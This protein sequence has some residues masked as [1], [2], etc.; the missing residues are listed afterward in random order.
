MK[1]F[2]F[3]LI[4]IFS[5]I[6]HQVPA[7]VFAQEASTIVDPKTTMSDLAFISPK[8]YSFGF[9]T[10]GDM[11]EA[12]FIYQNTTDIPLKVHVQ[13]DPEMQK[14]YTRDLPPQ[15][16]DTLNL[17]IKT[18]SA[19]LGLFSG[20]IKVQ[21]KRKNS[22]SSTLNEQLIYIDGYLELNQNLV[23]KEQ[24]IDLDTVFIGRKY[25]FSL[26]MNNK[27][28]HPVTIHNIYSWEKCQAT[29]ADFPLVLPPNSSAMIAMIFELKNKKIGDFE[30]PLFIRTDLV[31]DEYELM[32]RGFGKKQRVKS[33]IVE[34][35]IIPKIV[36]EMG[37][38]LPTSVLDTINETSKSKD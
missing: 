20:E 38:L 14:Y 32:I 17:R 3:L 6:L 21:Y 33:S 11:I 23:I 22:F 2:H 34:A 36:K 8:V 35:K 18:Q 29:T 24:V 27:N 5:L 12:S 25:N 7:I 30:V 31:V 1:K 28:D 10:C 13:S 26:T 9:K 15:Q 19:R 4:T 16:T 37:Q